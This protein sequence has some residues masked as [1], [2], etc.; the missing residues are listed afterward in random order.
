M[1][2]LGLALA[3]GLVAL[4]ASAGGDYPPVPAV[5]VDSGW[6]LVLRTGSGLSAYIAKTSLKVL[7]DRSGFA[8]WLKVARPDEA[9]MAP[10]AAYMLHD[11]DAARRKRLGHAVNLLNHALSGEGA[12]EWLPDV[13]ISSAIKQEYCPKI[14]R[15]KA[16]EERDRI[17]IG[18]LAA[19]TTDK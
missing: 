6:S 18:I 10:M 15:L 11:C 17:P 14:F 13:P 3:L 5:P 4:T 12:S 9:S 8:V 1:R 16:Q 2:A 7:P 19:T